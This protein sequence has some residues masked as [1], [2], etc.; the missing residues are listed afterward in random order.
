MVWSS[1]VRSS[2]EA[3]SAAS[4]K[5]WY[6]TCL[7]VRTVRETVE[8]LPSAYADLYSCSHVNLFSVIHLHEGFCRKV[9]CKSQRRTMMVST[10]NVLSDILLWRLAEISVALTGSARLLD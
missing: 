9:L 2:V 1:S 3:L 7:S 8:V 4:W 6:T 10:V 5:Q